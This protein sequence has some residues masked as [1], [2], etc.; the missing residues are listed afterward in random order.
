MI[1]LLRIG[2]AIYLIIYLLLIATI[3]TLIFLGLS[4]DSKIKLPPWNK[5]N[6]ILFLLVNIVACLLNT[7]ITRYTGNKLI[8][9]LTLTLICYVLDLE[10][11]IKVRKSK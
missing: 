8:V 5:K 9:A 4:K 3:I 10:F 7:M 2:I 1:N 11:I 6:F